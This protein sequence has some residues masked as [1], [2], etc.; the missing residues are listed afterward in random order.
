MDAVDV[1][2]RIDRIDHAAFV[3]SVRERQLDEDAVDRIV[4]VQLGNEREQ[5]LFAR[6][7]GQPQVAGLDSDLDR[8]LVLQPDVDLRGRVVADEHRRQADRPRERGHLARD[9]RA[10]ARCERLSVHHRRSHGG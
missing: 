3:E 10:D 4:C 5:I 2:H 9:L 1:F 7:R 6:R 8:R